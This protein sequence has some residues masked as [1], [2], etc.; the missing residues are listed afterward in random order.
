MK[1]NINSQHRRIISAN[2]SH[3]KSNTTVVQWGNFCAA[4]AARKY[5]LRLLGGSQ[6]PKYS[7]SVN[8]IESVSAAQCK[9]LLMGAEKVELHTVRRLA[10]WGITISNAQLHPVASPT[11]ERGIQHS[12]SSTLTACGRAVRT[13]K[14]RQSDLHKRNA[15]AAGH[16]LVQTRQCE[17]SIQ[18]IA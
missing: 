13:R 9:S 4:R 7:V 2:Q 3:H 14:C 8:T 10:E 18:A 6:A 1:K 5:M 16:V 12:A 17:S 15:E 11:L